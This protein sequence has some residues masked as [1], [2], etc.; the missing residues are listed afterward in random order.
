MQLQ[1]IAIKYAKRTPL[2]LVNEALVTVQNG[3]QGDCCGARRKRQITLLS[4]HSWDAACQD[5]GTVISWQMR[6]ANILVDKMQ[7]N[8]NSIGERILIGEDVV[9]EITGETTPCERMDQVYC[10][11]KSAL[12]PDWRGGITAR[13]LRGGHI[14]IGD[15]VLKMSLKEEHFS[16]ET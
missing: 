5:L 3:I 13:I 6:R 1:G 8:A 7:F 4:R 15:R 9:L 12:T 11:L 14:K 16:P 10:G 2:I